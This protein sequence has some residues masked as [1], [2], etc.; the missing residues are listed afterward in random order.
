MANWQSTYKLCNSKLQHSISTQH[1]G[2][3]K[4][5]ERML[6]TLPKENTVAH[7]LSLRCIM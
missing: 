5:T 7:V 3:P 6:K 4:R 2:R 1:T